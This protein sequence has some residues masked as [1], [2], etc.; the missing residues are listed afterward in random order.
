MET[1]LEIPLAVTDRRYFTPRE[2]NDI[3][4]L[5]R[6]HL[7]ALAES[8]GGVFNTG[9]TDKDGDGDTDI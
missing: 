6:G 9:Q 3:L 1:D 2:A 5:L 4:P 8:S 7:D